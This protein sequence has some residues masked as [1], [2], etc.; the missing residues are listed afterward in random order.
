MRQL[1][2][3]ARTFKDLCAERGAG[4]GALEAGQSPEALFISC[5]DSRVSPALI[6]GARPGD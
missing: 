1:I 2:A 3:H 5:S 4:L 6:T